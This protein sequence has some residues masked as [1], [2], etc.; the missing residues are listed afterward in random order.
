[1]GEVAND[2]GELRGV[3]M[4]GRGGVR[5]EGR[6]P[7]GQ[8]AL[9]GLREKRD[10]AGRPATPGSHRQMVTPKVQPGVK[11]RT[12]QNLA[13]CSPGGLLGET[14]AAV[15]VSPPDFIVSVRVRS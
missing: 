3:G 6:W 15:R 9:L 12:K 14:K 11:A 4:G 2:P 1:M 10:P 13:L 5:G 8:G 7:P